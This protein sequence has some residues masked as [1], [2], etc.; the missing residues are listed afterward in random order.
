MELKELLGDEL[1]AKVDEKLQE[2]NNGEPNKQKHVRYADLSEGR[3]VSVEKYTEK[4]TE[5]AGIRQQLT[6]ANKQIKS[7]KDMDIEGI[8]KSAAD[9]E[10]KYR[11]DTTALQGKITGLQKEAAAKDYLSGK[12]IRGKLA[13]RAAFAGMMNLEYKDGQ[14]VGADEYMKKLQ[15]EDPDSFEKEKEE[16]T[17]PGSWVR[18]ANRKD[19]PST[20]D[21]D[22]AYLKAKYGNN[23]YYRG[24]G[25]KQ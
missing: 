19:R 10:E 25:G 9:W 13:Q 12:K 16:E 8:R 5:L 3:Y 24:R 23:K 15:E 22:E 2:H 14:F 6:E 21:A 18:G 4:E 1:Y 20:L 17:K 11:T 7:Y